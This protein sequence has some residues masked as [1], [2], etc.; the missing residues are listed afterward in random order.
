MGTMV[1]YS[2]VIP[3]QLSKFVVEQEC[4]NYEINV[5]GSQYVLN[6]PTAFEK[7]LYIFPYAFV[8]T[9]I[10]GVLSAY[11]QG[12]SFSPECWFQSQGLDPKQ[13][14]I[15]L[16]Q[17]RDRYVGVRLPVESNH[18]HR[19]MEIIRRRRLDSGDA[20]ET[21][22]FEVG[23]D[24]PKQLD[25]SGCAFLDYVGGRLKTREPP[26]LKQCA[27]FSGEEIKTFAETRYQALTGLVPSIGEIDEKIRRIFPL[28]FR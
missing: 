25:I 18:I 27:S 6:F 22:E 23:N 21:W 14:D 19:Y 2:Y 20:Y 17:H 26:L 7:R 9:T 3:P 13:I 8:L 10:R 11:E 1:G 4:V 12:R 15:Y 28:Y 24:G 5:I 16:N